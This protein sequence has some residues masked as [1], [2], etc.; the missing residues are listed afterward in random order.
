YGPRCTL[1]S[2]T[3]YYQ[4]SSGKLQEQIINSNS[5]ITVIHSINTGKVILLFSQKHLHKRT[6][7]MADPE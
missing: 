2:F 1:T 3:Y 6:K 4:N 5:L 7:A